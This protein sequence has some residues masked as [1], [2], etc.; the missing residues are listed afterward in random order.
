MHRILTPGN[1][2]RGPGG[3]RGSDGN[4]RDLASSNLAACAFESRLPYSMPFRLTGRTA[5]SGAA[6]RGSNPRGAAQT[7]AAAHGCGSA[8]VRRTARVGT[9]RRLTCSYSNS[10]REVGLSSRRLRVRLPPSTPAVP[11]E[12]AQL[13]RGASPRTR[14]IAVRI[15]GS[16]LWKVNRTGA[17]LRC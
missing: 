6:N 5:A 17:G 16:A 12:L 3:A 8:F 11:A 2:V 15:R 7:H 14:R 10:G 4:R 9:G 13:E 1:G